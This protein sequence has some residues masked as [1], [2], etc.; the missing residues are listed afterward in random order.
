MF[1]TRQITWSAKA[2]KLHAPYLLDLVVV[3]EREK[4][5]SGP[6]DARISNKRDAN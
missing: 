6:A 4:T 1:S 2:G 5:Q 3:V